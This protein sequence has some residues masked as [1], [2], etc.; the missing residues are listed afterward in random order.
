[1]FVSVERAG[2]GPHRQSRGA[3]LELAGH[4]LQRGDR[5]GRRA[6]RGFAAAA[7]RKGVK[8][9]GFRHAASTFDGGARFLNR[10]FSIA[11]AGPLPG[12]RTVYQPLTLSQVATIS[13][14]S[15]T[16]RLAPCA[17]A[18]MQ[19]WFGSTRTF[20]PIGRRSKGRGATPL[21]SPCS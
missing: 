5:V 8:M 10:A 19:T 16:T 21:I 3:A 14:P 20:D 4:F 13:V 9:A 15:S 11:Y 12:A 1:M 17:A 7:A 6:Q 2:Q 18:V